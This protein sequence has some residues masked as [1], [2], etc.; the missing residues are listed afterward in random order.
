MKKRSLFVATAMLLV[1]VLVAT[2][3]TY[4]WFTS[5]SKATTTV[6]MSVSG[7]ES[8]EISTD[9]SNGWKTSLNNVTLWGEGVTKTWIDASTDNAGVAGGNFYSEKYENATN[10]TIITGYAQENGVAS[11]TINFRATKAGKVVFGDCDFDTNSNLLDAVKD[12]LRIGVQNTTDTSCTKIVATKAITDGTCV[13]AADV[14]DSV[15]DNAPTTGKQNAVTFATAG[16]VVVLD[17]VV[18]GYYTSSATF[19]FWVE[20][21]TCDNLDLIGSN[22]S[23][24]LTS[25]QFSFV[26][27]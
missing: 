2:G 24:I 10:E 21:T 22:L 3:A 5:V 20:G 12:S 14:N 23:N 13:A 27:A 4:A 15:V 18:D 9:K 26:A 1:A 6:Q 25:L 7:G 16:D 19:Y 17:D 11:V 8:L